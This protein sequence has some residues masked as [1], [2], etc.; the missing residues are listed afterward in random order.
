ME[1]HPFEARIVR[2]D[3]CFV[4]GGVPSTEVP[5]N[6]HQGGVWRP[7]RAAEVRQCMSLPFTLISFRQAEVAARGE[8]LPGRPPRARAF[9]LRVTN[10]EALRGELER[11]FS[12]SYASIYPDFPGFARFARSI[13]TAT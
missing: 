10:K 1:A 11:G 4:V 6:V 3:G 13:P 5:R 9:T 7:L 8:R 12:Y 2:Q